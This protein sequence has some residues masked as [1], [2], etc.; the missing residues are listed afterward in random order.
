MSVTTPLT[1]LGAA[2]LGYTL[3]ALP[4]GVL[5]CRLAGAPDVRTVGSGHTGGTNVARATGRAWIG[6]LSGL[7]DLAKAAAAVLLARLWC[8]G[9]VPGPGWAGAVAGAAAVVGHNWSAYIGFRGGVGLSTLVGMLAAQAPLPTAGALVV[10]VP[11]WLGARRLLRHDAR[12]TALTMVLVV[13]LLALAGAPLPALASGLLGALA[14]AAREVG[15]WRRE[16]RA[17]ESFTEQLTGRQ[18]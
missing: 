4:T 1:L 7:G 11:V 2:L 18:G 14:V 16:Y 12:S 17:G 9:A 15:D 5:A 8:P 10:A 13:P 3:G 6:A